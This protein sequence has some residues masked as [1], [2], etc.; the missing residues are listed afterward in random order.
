MATAHVGA[1]ELSFVLPQCALP[2][3]GVFL[4][5][6]GRKQMLPKL[7]AFIDHIGFFPGQ[8][9]RDKV[10]DGPD[11]PSYRMVRDVPRSYSVVK[12]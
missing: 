7:R 9:A 12:V 6:P 2:T 5:H 1:G 10:I 4:Y 11:S 3:P 8:M